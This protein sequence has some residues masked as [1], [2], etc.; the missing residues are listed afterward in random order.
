MFAVNSCVAEGGTVAVAGET[1]KA[2]TATA[3]LALSDEFATL[4]AVTVWFPAAEG[5][6]YKPA[7]VMVPTLEFPPPMPSTDQVTFRFE[8]FFMVALNWE[9]AP[10]KTSAAV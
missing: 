1:E 9:V 6:V 3:A 4:V 7:L 2:N 10:V 5:A 8:E